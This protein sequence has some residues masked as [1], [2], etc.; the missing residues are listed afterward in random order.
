MLAGY[1]PFDD[2]PANPE[3]DN[4]NLLYKYITTTPL[5]FPEYVTPHARDLLRRIL[6]PDPRKRADLF[7]VARH[8]WLSDYA[9][10]V[11][12]VTSGATTLGEIANTTVTACELSASNI[13]IAIVGLQS[14]TATQQEVPSL[15]RSASVREPARAT[16][17]VVS[18]PVGG[19][20]HQAKMDS[21]PSAEKTKA[22]RNPNRRTVQVEYVP[23]QSQTVRGEALPPIGSPKTDEYTSTPGTGTSK[24]RV[25]AG[26]EGLEAVPRQYDGTKPLDPS[27]SQSSRAPQQYYS[28]SGG[29][30]QQRPGSSSQRDTMVPPPR[31]PKDIPRSVSDAPGSFGQLPS[32]NSNRPATGGSMT[33]GGHSRLPSR[34]N[35]YSQPLAPTVATT[36]AHGRVT[37]PQSRSG[38]QYDISAPIPQSGYNQADS[39]GLPS[40]EPSSYAPPPTLGRKDPPRGHK[41]SNTLGNFFRTGSISGPRS[42]PQ[43]PGET[44]QREK[45]H[46]PTSMKTSIPNE[47]TPRKSTDSRRP[48]FGFG[49]KSSDLRKNND[50][51][52]EEKPRRFSLLPASFSFK[53][54]TTQGSGKESSSEFRPA[55]ERRQSSNLVQGI[56]SRSQSRPQT[57]AYSR[58]Q[59]QA[60]PFDGGDDYDGS[61]DRVRDLPPQ[62]AR[63]AERGQQEY[64]STRNQDQQALQGPSNFQQPGQSYLGTPTESEISLQPRQQQQRQDHRPVYPPGFGNDSYEDEPRTSM[65]QS[66]PGRGP[67]V[68]QKPNR[69]FADAYE[70][71][72]GPGEGNHAG[73]SGAA[74]RV[75]DFFRR[76]GR[77]RAG[78]DRA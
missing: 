8:S 69:R 76:R 21:G 18:P 65:Q 44:P 14:A 29:R 12:Q 53:S 41:R 54:F 78:D 37:Q 26:Q 49:R 63:R 74:K 30:T 62:Q 9:H 71:D 46:P 4:I 13:V 50:I 35:S 25:R 55:S 40:T 45:R 22:P 16:P 72:Q 47:T 27:V 57:M 31:P 11:A 48:S 73:S 34:G 75:M 33:P 2:D 70:Q 7:E 42:Q 23:P 67:S 52:K 56:T 6:V 64:N 66:R 77:A 58:G 3:G 60:R 51:S 28:Q 17:A 61:R 36:N 39:I 43:S 19:L 59:S 68:L 1:L 24:S 38:K 20:T 5:T 10:V 32:S 15:V